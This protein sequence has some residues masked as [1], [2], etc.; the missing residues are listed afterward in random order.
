MRWATFIAD[1]SYEERVGVLHDEGL[2]ALAPGA[3]LVS[4][5]GDD[6]EK[7]ERAAE[8]AAKDP[9]GV[10]DPNAV[11][12]LSPVPRPPS[13]RD[14]MAF[15]VHFENVQRGLGRPMPKVYYQQPVFYFSNPAGIVGP[16]ADIP[17]APGSVAWD[18]ELEAAAIIGRAGRDLHP[19]D[20]Q[21]HIAGY[22]VLC[23]F[24]ARDLQGQEIAA[25]LGPAKGK[26]TATSVGPFLVTA[27]EL[28][29][30]RTDRGFALSMRASVN[31]RIYSE[32]TFD[33]LS[34]TLG[35]LLAYASRGT[36]LRPGDVIG[37]GTVGGGCILE[38]MLA[39][40]AEQ[41][42]WLKVGDEVEL[43]I[44]HL[45]TLRHR[46]VAGPDIIAIPTRPVPE[47]ITVA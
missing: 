14:F 27:D 33:T 6:G 22:A 5:L 36:A 18:Y 40:G 45:G 13:F 37:T 47:G 34:W 44:E 24:S 15:Q 1:N 42:P 41:Y 32:G 39:H 16:N 30:H 23:D 7:L 46:I 12:L 17:I 43:E 8:T 21:S 11:T 35:E 9:H 10:F 4:L 26:D 38:Q 3:R 2:H 29:P 31:G 19:G 20:A 28:E 25:N